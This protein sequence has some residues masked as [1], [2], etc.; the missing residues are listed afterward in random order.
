[1]ISNIE[2]KYL[3]ITITSSNNGKIVFLSFY[4]PPLTYTKLRTNSKQLFIVDKKRERGTSPM[5]L[6]VKIY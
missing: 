1:V 3:L 6:D 2:N 5:N 4:F